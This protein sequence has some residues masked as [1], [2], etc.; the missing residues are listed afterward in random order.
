MVGD[1]A[2]LSERAVVGGDRHGGGDALGFKDTEELLLRGCPKDDID[3]ATALAQVLGEED[4]RSCAVASADQEAGHGIAR[5]RERT[6]E[7][8]HDVEHITPATLGEPVRARAG[9]CDDEVDRAAVDPA[10]LDAVD[11]EGPAQE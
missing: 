4:E 5:E 10:R 3:S 7:W 2:R 8:G 6:P 9:I 11:G 1:E